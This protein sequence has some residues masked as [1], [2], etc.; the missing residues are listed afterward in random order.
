[1]FISKW[2]KVH[3]RHWLIL[4]GWMTNQKGK[5]NGKKKVFKIFNTKKKKNYEGNLCTLNE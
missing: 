3:E 2:K 4:L 5:K 1:M